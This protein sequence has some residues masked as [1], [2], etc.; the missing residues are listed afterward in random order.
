MSTTLFRRPARRVGPAMPADE[1]ELQE[2][3][4]VPEPKSN[5]LST[6]LTYLPMA[7]MS[8]SM[9]MMML[10]SS[11]RSGGSGPLMY[12]TGGMMGVA[13]VTMIVGQLARA[14]NDRKHQQ[15]GDRR[16]YLRYLGQVRRRVREK[17]GEQ[18]R[19]ASWTHPNP[20]S[21]WSLVQSYRLWERRASHEDFGEVRLGSGTQRS[22]VSS[23]RRSPSRS[24]TSNR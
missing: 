17:L 22:A 1:V 21:L 20:R 18:H 2:P 8:G 10:Q 13:M 5:G 12:I 11:Q 23:S 7:V 4:T 9:M 14:S 16:D 6:V 15:T 24:R 3:P 19:A